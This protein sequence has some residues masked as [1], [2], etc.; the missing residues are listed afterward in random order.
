MS[1]TSK[2]TI[3]FS[4]PSSFAHK[5]ARAYIDR[6][7]CGGTESM[8]IDKD[9]IISN[10]CMAWYTHENA[11]RNAREVMKMI[12]LSMPDIITVYVVETNG[13]HWREFFEDGESSGRQDAEICYPPAPVEFQVHN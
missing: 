6:E 4:E 10:P 13:D 12:S 8:E 11:K 5:S 1:T 7:L 9:D 2:I 3:E